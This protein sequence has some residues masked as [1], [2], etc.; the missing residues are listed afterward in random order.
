VGKAEIQGATMIFPRKQSGFTLVEMLVVI[1]II[2]VLVALLVPAIGVVRE[3]AR[4]TQCLNNQ[5]EIGQALLAYEQAKQRMPGVLNSVIPG[6]VNPQTTWVMEIF[7]DLGRNQLMNQWR[8][9]HD[10]TQQPIIVDLL[11]CPSNKDARVAGGLSYRVNLGVP[12]TSPADTTPLNKRRLFRSRS[13]GEADFSSTSLSSS[14]KTVMLSEN[15]SIGKW[16]YDIPASSN[17]VDN[18]RTSN[19]EI[20]NLSFYWPYQYNPSTSTTPNPQTIGDAPS[21]ILSSYHRVKIVT[22]FFDG[23]CESLPQDTKCWKV[24][25]DPDDMPMIY[26]IP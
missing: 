9:G 11:I 3:T 25:G 10:G 7:D 6:S 23:H 4:Q 5:R 24:Q 16:D 12:K 19:T 17:V 20:L 26:G 1:A 21:P 2:G 13:A 14:S 22:T 8:N 18:D 15:L